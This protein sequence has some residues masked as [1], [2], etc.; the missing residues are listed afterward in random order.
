MPE[1]NQSET[2]LNEGLHPYV[3]FLPPDQKVRVLSA[4]FG[5]KAAVDVLRFSLKN[6]VAN[7]IYQKKLVEELG[8]SNKTVIGNLKNLTKLGLLKEQMEKSEREGRVVWVKTYE[9]LDAGKWFALLLADDR[10]LPEAEKAEI[11]Q[12]LFRTY[13]RW[14][15]EVSSKL[16]IEKSA[17]EKAFLD[18]MK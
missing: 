12:N 4:I 9:L 18:E 10:D 6:G 14:V 11:L 16:H 15:R 17:L 13:V 5:S 3:V 2:G 1:Q 8:Y 7:R